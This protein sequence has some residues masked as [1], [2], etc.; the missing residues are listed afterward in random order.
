MVDI[1]DSLGILRMI[2]GIVLW[3]V[4]WLAPVV[5][6]F[7]LAYYFLGLPLRRQERARLL[8]GLVESGLSDGKSVERT[9][10]E[11][12]DT[13]DSTL[14]ERFHHLADHFKLGFSLREALERVPQMLPPQMVAM[15]VAGQELGDIQKVIAACRQLLGDANSH[16]QSAVN[17]LMVM[18]FAVTP[19]TSIMLAVIAINVLPQFRAV[20]ADFTIPRQTAL[21]F[22]MN[23]HWLVIGLQFSLVLGIWCCA[24]FY[25]G[26]PHL[27]AWTNR[28]LGARVGSFQ[29]LLPWRRLRMQRDFATMLGLLLDAGMPEPEGFAVGVGLHSEPGLFKSVARGQWP[30]WKRVWD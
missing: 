5:G 7:W 10:I 2:F 18:A 12:S 8:L 1:D 13:L 24:A 27:T 3:L 16:L 14:G 28:L 26:G 30:V 20:A 21:E 15:L 4:F 17:Y 23:Y 11:V 9:V 25:I 22:F 6:F 29:Y 19:A